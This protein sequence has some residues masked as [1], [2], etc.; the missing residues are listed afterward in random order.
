LRA[1]EELD[2]RGLIEMNDGCIVSS[3]AL[4]S[5]AVA[6]RMSPTVLRGLHAT[7][8]ELIQREVDP[9]HAARLRWD[10][11]EHWRI[12]GNHAQAITVLHECAQIAIEIGRPADALK[13]Y[14][15]ALMLNSTDDVKLD[16]VERALDA[17]WFALDFAQSEDLLTLRGSLRARLRVPPATHDSYEILAF[18]R[19]LHNDGDPLS[20]VAQL[21]ECVKCETASVRHRLAAA[22]QLIIIADLTIDPNLAAGTLQAI[23][24]VGPPTVGHEHV[25][26]MFHT[27]FG[28]AER[29]R[30]L[31]SKIA[32]KCTTDLPQDIGLLLT[33]GYAQSRLGYF[34]AAHETLLRALYGARRNEMISV[35]MHATL[36]FSKLYWNAER[37]SEC[38]EWFH[39]LTDL[40]SRNSAPEILADYCVLG[41][42]L[43]ARD[44]LYAS[45]QEFIERARQCRQTCLELPRLLLGACSI[46]VHIQALEQPCSEWELNDLLVLHMRAQRLGAQDEVAT[47][48]VRALLAQDR[49]TEAILLLESYAR[50]RRADGF[51]VRADLAH[52]AEELNV[53][54]FQLC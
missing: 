33:V 45:A 49:S 24:D 53:P 7:A 16:L 19:I 21:R 37:L 13:T 44:A 15:H 48:L 41:A 3:H 2:D 6:D 40:L 1:V 52:L 36:F 26:M 25:E 5:D 18:A 8:A 12:A 23:R 39:Q 31:A 38:R 17:V 42:R 11:A 9:S 30:A 27:C 50:N 14:R 28:K 47:A 46:D 43:A 29:A 51:R 10:C 35:E 54:E 4:L 32:S 22:R 20:V 34:D